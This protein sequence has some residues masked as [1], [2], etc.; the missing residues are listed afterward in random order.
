V[1]SAYEILSDPKKKQQFDQF[2]EAGFDPSGG[3]GGFHPGAGGPFSGFGGA[4]G[5]FSGFGGGPFGAD[6]SF[7]DL[8]NAATGSGGRRGKSPFE[9]CIG[10]DIQ[11]QATISFM[12]AARGTPLEIR[13]EPQVQCGTCT[14]S[15][16]KAGTKTKECG[17]CGGTGT[18]VHFMR[19]G[20]QMAAT[21][22]SCSG[23]GSII[24]PGSECKSC[25]G[26]G[27]VHETRTVNIDV[28]AGVEEGMRI[29][30]SGEGEAP[31][32]TPGVPGGR[33]RRGDLYVHIVVEPHPKF[34]RKGS[35]I[36]HTSTIP[37][38]TALLGGVIKIPTLDGNV[39]LKVPSG[40]NTGD[41]ITISGRGMKRLNQGRR[42]GN[43]DLKIEF[44]VKM[45]NFLTPPPPP[46]PNSTIT[47]SL[48]IPHPL[49]AHPP[50]AAG[51]R[52]QRQDGQAHHERQSVR[53]RG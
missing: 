39:D 31:P 3:P 24:P 51:R 38:T 14:G 5:G 26:S 50:R 18:R 28:P 29:R 7:E 27:V 1:Q 13:I 32:A 19:G 40:T 52:V 12:D 33:S 45:P 15:G 35:D 53:Q 36:L 23:T 41:T 6:F 8:F 37:L 11:V 42:G 25:D 44:K 22:D 9:D 47:N 48:Q 21:C 43:G 49:A 34:S 20:F 16:L 46:P 10:A 4:G 30:V 2:G 17:R